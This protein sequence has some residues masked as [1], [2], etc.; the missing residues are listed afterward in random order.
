[1]CTTPITKREAAVAADRLIIESLSPKRLSWK[2]LDPG[3][4]W[5]MLAMHAGVLLAP[6]YF[7]WSA[8][9]AALVLHWL[10]ASVGIC[11]GFHRYLSH[12][13]LKLKTPSKFFVL[14]AGSLSVEGGPSRW[15]AIHRLHHAKS[16]KEGDPH[17]PRVSGM[18]SHLYWMFLQKCERGDEAL[19]AKFGPDFQQD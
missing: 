3:V 4:F 9:A 15:A 1:M 11:L 2:T 17:S 6:F 7:S 19:N 8:V 12:R 10:T 13:S 14:L 5:W 18:W 16:D